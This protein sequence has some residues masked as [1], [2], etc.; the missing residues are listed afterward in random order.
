[1]FWSLLLCVL[2]LLLY[3]LGSIEPLLC[4]ACAVI[5]LLYFIY[6][7]HQVL[8]LKRIGDSLKRDAKLNYLRPFAHV[9]GL[10]LI[11]GQ[12]CFLA[13]S[14]DQKLAIIGENAQEGLP[15]QAIDRILDLRKREV[16]PFVRH[17]QRLVEHIPQ[18][19][20]L[21]AC[22]ILNALQPAIVQ[23]WNGLVMLELSG[24]WGA[25]II[26]LRPLWGT[27]SWD[28]LTQPALKSLCAGH[29]EILAAL[30]A[31]VEQYKQETL[32]DQEDG[33][34]HSVDPHAAQAQH[35][36]KKADLA[37]PAHV[38]KEDYYES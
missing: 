9:S 32:T 27:R 29:N 17:V 1:M 18:T 2:A 35:I 19:A 22:H 16:K 20:D 34:A 12:N 26:I 30:T 25:R 31:E 13:L 15:I 11:Q 7:F 38:D 6:E 24:A 8:S 37:K 21:R 23:A 5:G 14:E 4:L 3:F 36:L 33:L 10:D 28:I